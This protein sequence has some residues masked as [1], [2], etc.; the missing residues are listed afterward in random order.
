VGVAA[1]MS[2]FPF[3]GWGDSF[4]GDLHAQ[5]H[6]AVEFFTQTKV[7]VE[8]LAEGVEPEVL[9]KRIL[10]TKLLAAGFLPLMH[11][12]KASILKT[13]TEK[14]KS[15]GS[16]E[17]CM[18]ELLVGNAPCSVGTLETP[19]IRVSQFRRT[20]NARRAGGDGLY[21][22]GIGRL[23]LQCPTEPSRLS[24]ELAKRNHVVMLGAFVPVELKNP[25]AHAEGNG[26]GRE[27]GAS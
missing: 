7:V 12:C 22:N 16:K 27:D 6:H 5:A 23:G 8:T 14:L 19:R 9:K 21:R 1:P 25:L 24:E 10:A 15:R 17:E 11:T 3:S 18:N 2:T 4:F 13:K 26:K 20:Q